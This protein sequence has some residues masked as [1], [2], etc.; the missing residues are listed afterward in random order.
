MG[1]RK[2]KKV[3]E[4]SRGRTAPHAFELGVEDLSCS[5]RSHPE[6]R[7]THEADMV[8]HCVSHATRERQE[9]EMDLRKRKM[10][11]ARLNNDHTPEAGYG[12]AEGFEK[13]PWRCFRTA[14]S[15]TANPQF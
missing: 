9:F 5:Q 12:N 3:A 2:E 1:T 7:K 11:G 10:R 4:G 13:V 15:H 6:Q 14:A 8:T